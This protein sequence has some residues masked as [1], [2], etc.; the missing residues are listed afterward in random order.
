M[1]ECNIN[2][3][4]LFGGEKPSDIEI[5][6][7]ILRLIDDVS[8]GSPSY[9]DHGFGR[10]YIVKLAEKTLKTMTNPSAKKLLIDKI[11]SGI[12]VPSHNLAEES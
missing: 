11:N 4:N 8:H 10:N 6:M 2:F 9:K 12:P 5:A 1:A 7:H 3:E